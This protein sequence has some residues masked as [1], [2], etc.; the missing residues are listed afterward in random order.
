LVKTL[1]T[2]GVA[3][4]HDFIDIP[5]KIM[6]SNNPEIK[7]RFLR[8]Y[9]DTDGCLSFIN[10]GGK[11]RYPRLNVSSVSLKLI[12]SASRLF[13]DI[14]FSGSMW[15]MKIGKKSKKPLHRFEMKGPRLIS[16][17]YNQIGTRNPSSI[18]KYKIWSI[19]GE[20]R[21]NTTFYERSKILKDIEFY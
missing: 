10:K 1:E 11:F 3:M 20:C 17:W 16:K 14:G 8:G 7:A 4:K 19:T 21:T 12:K 5:E 9:I 6:K 15:T 2:F 18:T 13:N